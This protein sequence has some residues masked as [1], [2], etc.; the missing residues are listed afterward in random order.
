M[1]PAFAGFF[2]S[3]AAAMAGSVTSNAAAADLR[4]TVERNLRP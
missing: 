2:S 4:R 3:D 1:S